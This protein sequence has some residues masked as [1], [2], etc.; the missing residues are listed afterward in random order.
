MLNSRVPVTILVL[1]AIVGFS[2][3]TVAQSGPS[4]VHPPDPA[5]KVLTVEASCGQCNFGLKAKRKSC[6]LAV[7]INGKAYFVDGAGINDYGDAHDDQGFCNAVRKAEVQ[8]AV[9][10]N[11]FVVSSFKLLPSTAT[12]K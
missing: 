3:T 8:G 7:R 12:D 9:V 2:L 4:A 11:R 10:K 5:K 1:V 6:D